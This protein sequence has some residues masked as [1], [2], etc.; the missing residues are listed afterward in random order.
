VESAARPR[1]H[2][3]DRAYNPLWTPKLRQVFGIG[4]HL[5]DKPARR[6]EYAGDDEDRSSDGLA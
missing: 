1:V 4:K 6:I 3:A 2:F 5:E